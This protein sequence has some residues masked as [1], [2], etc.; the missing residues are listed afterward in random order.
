MR[1]TISPLRNSVFWNF[2]NELNDLFQTFEKRS[3]ASVF[4]KE[5]ESEFLLGLELPGVK[6]D[7][8][9]LEVEGNKLTI[10]A[11]RSLPFDSEKT[12]DLSK[13][14]TIPKGINREKIEARIADGFLTVTLPKREVE[15]PR[16]IEV[17]TTLNG[18]QT[19]DNFIEV[20][21]KA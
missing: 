15:K 9:G 5:N 4:T 16:K 19:T 12:N 10:T 21:E 17:K 13:S 1:T 7:D 14:F 2:N 6:G 11:K 8:L 18:N 20:E 3:D